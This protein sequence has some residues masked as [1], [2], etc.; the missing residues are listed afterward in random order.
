MDALLNNFTS[1][2]IIMEEIEG[3]IDHQL[4]G[5]LALVLSYLV[6]MRFLFGGEMKLHR[7]SVDRVALAVNR[8]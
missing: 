1:S 3:R 2:C 4:L 8:S 5:V 6:E 7:G